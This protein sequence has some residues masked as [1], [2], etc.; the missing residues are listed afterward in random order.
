[1]SKD[2]NNLASTFS[3]GRISI[4]IL[5]KPELPKCVFNCDSDLAEHLNDY[6][7]TKLAF[8]KFSTNLLI[9]KPKSGKTSLLYSFFKGNK[10]DNKILKGV[11]STIY[12]FQ[13]ENSRM[14]M[15]D[16]IF[17]ILPEEQKFNE[18][19]YEN[20]FEVSER[21]KDDAKNGYTSCIIYDDMGAYL[22]NKDT[23]KLFKELA[24]NKRH[25]KLS[26]LFLVQTWFSV[27]K[28]L[29]RLWD[30]IFVFRVS[31]NEL[32]NIF[33]EVVEQKKEI[34]EDIAKIVFDKPYEYLVINTETQRLF[35]GFDEIII[36]D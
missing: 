15:T 20:L 16:N 1:M 33:D 18:L 22:K 12:L 17:E 36:E 21:I 30:N 9:G 7:L 4:K 8:S 32:N 5:D 23:L 31:K 28:D 24:M 25:Y 13:P 29:R 35:K 27:E 19:T 3:K 2:G 6:E 14:S 11:F 34:V 10:K 26:Q